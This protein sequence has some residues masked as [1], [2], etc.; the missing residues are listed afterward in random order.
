MS[1]WIDCGTYWLSTH[2]Q[3]SDGWFKY[4]A[5]RLTASNFGAIMPDNTYYN[6]MKI[7]SKIL[8]FG[9]PEVVSEAMLHG[10]KFEDSAR[11]YYE[12]VTGTKV[13]ELGLAIPKWDNRIGASL[14]GV[15]IG[16]D[17][18]IEI[19]CPKRMYSEIVGACS[20]GITGNSFIKEDH[21]A[22]MQ[23]GMKIANKSWCDYVVYATESGKCFI[24]RVD[25]DPSYW[26]DQLY[27]AICN[28]FSH[29][30]K[31]GPTTSDK[32]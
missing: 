21:Y 12:N 9:Q 18:M 28:F 15:V 31:Y 17:G 10:V 27:P 13:E 29:I 8:G 30:H 14:D 25:W 7:A 32:N 6:P 3:R 26:D 4:R 19:K 22:Q 16:T 11:E 20:L 23:G 2:P 5:K 1:E 24:H